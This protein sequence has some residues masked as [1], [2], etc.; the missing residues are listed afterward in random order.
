MCFLIDDK[1]F[2]GDTLFQGSVGRS[3]F[4]RWKS[5]RTYKQYKEKL[6]PLGDETKVY[7]GHGPVQLLMYEKMRN[8]F[9]QDICFKQ[10]R[11]NGN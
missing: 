5:W 8:P 3:D 6:I 1:L 11:K 4:Y 10:R 2:T 7:P 9:L